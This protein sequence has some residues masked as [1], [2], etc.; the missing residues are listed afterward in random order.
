MTAVIGQQTAFIKSL[1]SG[2]NV[3]SGGAGTQA[4]AQASASAGPVAG[5]NAFVNAISSARTGLGVTNSP[6]RPGLATGSTRINRYA[7]GT[8][9]TEPNRAPTSYEGTPHRDLPAS[10]TITSSAFDKSHKKK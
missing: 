4:L 9:R 6:L 3:Q 1:I 8:P 10:E 7:I 2:F 5:N